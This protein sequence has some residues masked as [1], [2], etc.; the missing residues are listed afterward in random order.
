VRAGEKVRQA[1]GRIRE[2]ARAAGAE[3]LVVMAPAS[4]QVSEPDEL[5]FYP[6]NVDFRDRDRFDPDHPQRLMQE[7]A[8]S[9]GIWFLDLRPA[10]S[11]GGSYQ[12][13]NMHW[14]ANGHRVVAR[15]VREA[16]D[17]KGLPARRGR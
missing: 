2:A 6:S 9:L 12:R 7:I 4:I 8:D 17:R 11:G 1:L 13:R 3:L 5:D 16:L 10:L 14:T 15:A